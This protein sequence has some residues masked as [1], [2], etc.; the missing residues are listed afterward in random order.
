MVALTLLLPFASHPTLC[1]AGAISE[2][3]RSS[4][5]PLAEKHAHVAFETEQVGGKHPI[6]VANYVTGRPKVADVK[7]KTAEEIEG[8]VEMFRS[9]SGRKMTKF[10][11]TKVAA[12]PEGIQGGWRPNIDFP[13]FTVRTST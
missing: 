6:V 7:N 8:V 12:T 1:G 13:E 2:F 5:V 4:M 9:T 3:I 11:T 10:R